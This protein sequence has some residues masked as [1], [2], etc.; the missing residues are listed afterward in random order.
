MPPQSSSKG[1]NPTQNPQSSHVPTSSSQGE[2]EPQAPGQDS[3]QRNEKLNSF[4]RVM[5]AME[6]ELGRKTGKPRKVNVKGQGPTSGLN[7]SS[8]SGLPPLPTEEDL[9]AMSE[10]DL[11]AMDRELRAALKGAGISD[12]EESDDETSGLDK[13]TRQKLR[14]L[15]QDSKDE[16]NMIKGLLDSYQAQGGAS[17]AAGNL[18]GRLVDRK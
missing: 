17:G 18:L 1:K 14:G 12:D 15:G 2:S 10:A 6:A 3:Q 7:P 8:G 9:E 5:D 4:D 11:A 16:F 13:E